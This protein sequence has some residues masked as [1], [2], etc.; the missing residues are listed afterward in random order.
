[1]LT[2]S[3]KT[4]FWPKAYWCRIYDAV[5][6]RVSVSGPE[7]LDPDSRDAHSPA[8][9]LLW[10]FSFVFVKLSLSLWIHLVFSLR[11]SLGL[12]TRTSKIRA[13]P[14]LLLHYSYSTFVYIPHI[15]S[16]LEPHTHTIFPVSEIVALFR[17]FTP[18]VKEG[19]GEGEGGI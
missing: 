4:V 13:Q 3:K 1:M 15:L 7:F 17:N 10:W 6:T 19:K 2:A 5:F 18:S 8:P 14:K 11:K 16:Y 9:S 12:L